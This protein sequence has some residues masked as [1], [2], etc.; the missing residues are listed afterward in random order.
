MIAKAPQR[1]YSINPLRSEALCIDKIAPVEL[2]L[3]AGS[4]EVHVKWGNCSQLPELRFQMHSVCG[5]LVG[6]WD[7]RKLVLRETLPWCR[8][9]FHIRRGGRR[10]TERRRLVE[11]FRCEGGPNARVVEL[12]RAPAVVFITR[13]DAPLG[14]APPSTSFRHGGPTT[15]LP[16]SEGTAPAPRNTTRADPPGRAEIFIFTFIFIFTRPG[17]Y[18]NPR[19]EDRRRQ[20]IPDSLRIAVVRWRW[21]NGRRGSAGSCCH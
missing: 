15:R 19:D 20:M 2:E 17:G 14:R 4:S 10:Y 7:G 11:E 18:P 12:R 5:F 21:T 16:L 8:P 3:R 13:A 1:G 9:A 6:A